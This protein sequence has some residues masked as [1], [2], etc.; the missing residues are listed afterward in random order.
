MRIGEDQVEDHQR[1]VS[2]QDEAASTAARLPRPAAAR[3]VCLRVPRPRR[4]LCSDVLLDRSGA[5]QPRVQEDADQ[6][7][8]HQ[9]GRQRRRGGV[10]AG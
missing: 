4:W 2:R 1:R 7:R 8:R 5:Q 10:V 3:P 9:D 6:H